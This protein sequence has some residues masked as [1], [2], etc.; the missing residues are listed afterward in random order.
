[1]RNRWQA[2]PY[3]PAALAHESLARLLAIAGRLAHATLPR[4]RTNLWRPYAR[5]LAGWPMRP[6]RAWARIHGALMR[7]LWQ[8]GP[9]DPGALAHESL[10]RLCVIAGRLAHASLPR[11]RRKSWGSSARSPR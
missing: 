11:L 2:G 9:Y 4:L 10:A 3:D 1:M 8:A 7:N 6:C 5:L